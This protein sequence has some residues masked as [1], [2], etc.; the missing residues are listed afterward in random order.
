MS[1]RPVIALIEDMIDRIQRIERYVE[2]LDHGTFVRDEK[3]LDSVV[4]NLEVIGEAANR[5]PAEF[6]QLHSE[7][8]WRRI[9]GLRHRI[10]HEYFDVDHDLVWSIITS[11][12]PKLKALL[13]ALREKRS[14][15]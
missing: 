4:R 7:M 15:A 11:E 9:V 3:T 13:V 10:V 5:L 1:R 6:T 12:L 14:G 2:G 8:P